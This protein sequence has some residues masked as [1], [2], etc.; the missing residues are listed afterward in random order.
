M[1]VVNAEQAQIAEEAG[2]VSVMALRKSQQIS[3]LLVVW[4]EWLILVKSPRS[5]MRCIP[6]MASTNRPLCGSSSPGITGV[7]MIDESELT[8]AD[9]ISIDKKKFSIPFVWG[10]ESR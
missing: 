2:A 3:E 7:D 6:V 10:Q 9:E 8:P 5:L 1:D 4:L